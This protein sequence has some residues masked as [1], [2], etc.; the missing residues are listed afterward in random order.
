MTNSKLLM[1]KQVFSW[2]GLPESIVG[3]RDSRLTASAMRALCKHVQVKLKLSTA[4]HPQTDGESERFHSTMLQMLRAFVNHHH[5]DWSEHIPALLYA[6]HNTIHTATGFTPRMLLFGWC[7]RDL[8]A[9]LFA[10]APHDEKVQCGDRDIDVW[11]NNRSHALRKAQISLEGAREAMIRAHKASGNHHVYAAGDLVKISTRVLPLRITSTQKP[12]LLPKYIGPFS[13]VSVSDTVVQV[14]LPES[15]KLV[16]DKFNVID[17]RPWLSSDRSLD[18]AYPEVAPHPAL[19][20]IV[21]LL[22]RKKFGRA[23]KRIG[24]YLDIPCQY[25][26]VRKN[27]EHEWIKSSALTEPGEVQLIKKFE[28][29]FPRSAS[30]P[31]ESVKAYG[32]QKLAQVEEDISDDE[33]DIGWHADVERHY[34]DP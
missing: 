32:A 23:P 28:K 1:Y 13:V 18:V 16:H 12:K 27:G 10:V 6:Y 5:S 2:V 19:N 7:P 22:D 15:Y 17:V 14:K 26:A 8:R 33:L 4:Y 11:L 21:Q 30:L 25:Y 3:D 29:N 31:C 34:G 20:P 24:S 9:P